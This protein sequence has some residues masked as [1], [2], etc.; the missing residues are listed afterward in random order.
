MGSPKVEMPEQPSYEETFESALRTQLEYA[1]QILEA[2]K[3][4]D[5]QYQEL[6]QQQMAQG[7]SFLADQIGGAG[8][9]GRIA[10]EGLASIITDIQQQAQTRAV[11]GNVQRR[12]EYAPQARENYRKENKTFAM[13]EDA[14]IAG[15]QNPRAMSDQTRSEV[16]DPI[17]AQ[18]ARQGR[19]FDNAALSA[20]TLGTEAV[21]DR[22]EDRARAFAAGI[23]AV[24]PYAA[25]NTG[26]NAWQGQLGQLAGISSSFD[27]GQIL[28]PAAGQQYA[29]DVYANK[30]NAAI[31]QAQAQANYWGGLFSGAGNLFGGIF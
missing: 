23:S 9:S 4:L 28:N 24:D 6:N 31:G 30:T 2:K 16:V 14:A 26:G 13:L 19:V 5:P 18:Y 20:A 22:R 12:A 7:L 10:N 15:M 17:L 27:Q 21:Q 11:E 29:L 1:P 3:E 8:T 25:V